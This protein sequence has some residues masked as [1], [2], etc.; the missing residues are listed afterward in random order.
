MTCECGSFYIGKTRQE[1]G[2][3]VNQHLQTMHIGNFYVPLG[4]HVRD[5]HNY[6]MPKI[7]FMALDRIHIPLRGG[8]WNKTLLQLEM[9]WIT[10][11]KATIPPGLNEAQSYRPFLPG[12]SSGKKD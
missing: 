8:D 6:K 7:N 3:R 12:F 1:F 2:K 5:K 11:L 4:R 10:L 9:R